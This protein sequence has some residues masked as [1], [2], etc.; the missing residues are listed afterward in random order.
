MIGDTIGGVPSDYRVP[1]FHV[2]FDSSY[3]K[4]SERG[5]LA[6]TNKR[7]ARRDKANG[8]LL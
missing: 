1:A 6:D 3:P 5:T 7:V 2:F 4:F 8:L